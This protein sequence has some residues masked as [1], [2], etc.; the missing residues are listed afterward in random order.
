M[1][2]LYIIIT[3]LYPIN[4]SC[5]YAST[6]M[7]TAKEFTPSKL[8]LMMAHIL[9]ML[10][11]L[12]SAPMTS[13][14]NKELN[15]RKDSD[16]CSLKCLNPNIESLLKTLLMCVFLIILIQFIYRTKTLMIIQILEKINFRIHT[17]Q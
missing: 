14:A 5:I 8:C 12:V 9:L 13:L 17:R 6:W 7:K 4:S 10:I 3:Y 11:L 16:S 2:S 15:A 1:E